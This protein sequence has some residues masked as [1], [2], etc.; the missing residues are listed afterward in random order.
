MDHEGWNRRYETAEYVWQADPNQFVAE[1]LGDLEP[2]EAIDLAA[3]E[4]RNAIWLAERGWLVTA[5]DF[6]EVGLT[7]ANRL[8]DDRG[9]EI[10]TIVADVTTWEPASPV[11]LVVLAYLQLP[12]DAQESVL[13]RVAG[14]VRPSGTV[15]VIAHDRSNVAD[16]YGGPS[17]EDVCYDLERTTAALEPLEID[18]AE[19]VE[20]RL[21]TPDGERVALDTLIIAHKAEGS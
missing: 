13:R 6:S 17:V 5:V 11:D 16:G 15:F 12:S 9:V 21:D 20:R 14:W 10:E 18:R 1:H 8:A 19:V 7:K 4:G 3:G 2:G